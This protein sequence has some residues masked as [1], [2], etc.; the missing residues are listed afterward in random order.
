[1][2]SQVSNDP[3]LNAGEPWVATDPRRPSIVLTAWTTTTENPAS[4]TKQGYCGLARSTDGGQTWAREATQHLWGTQLGEPG[5]V[6]LAVAPDGT[7]YFECDLTASSGRI[8]I[9]KSTDGGLSWSPPVE[10]FG[11]DRWPAATLANGTPTVSWDRPV[12]VVD[13]TTG[14]VYVSASDD[15]LWGRAVAVSTDRGQTWSAPHLLDPNGQSDWGDVI[16]AA[17]GVLAAGYVVDP[18]SADYRLAASRAVDCAQPCVVF[19][20]SADHGVTWSR[21]VVPVHGAPGGNPVNLPANPRVNVAADPAH[22]GRFA[23]LLPTNS[24]ESLEIWVTEDSGDHWAR[25]RV[26]AAPTG[27][28]QAKWWVAY[29]PTGA[30]GAVWRTVHSDGSYDVSAVVSTDGGFTFGPMVPLT[31]KPSPPSGIGD[32]CACNVHLDGRTL[33]TAWGD[34]RTGHREAWFARFPYAGVPTGAH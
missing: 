29:S 18:A 19:E 15:A 13:P 17:G 24:Y 9:V 4:I 32:D 20:T 30:L 27:D 22:P 31:S 11:A 14:D 34:S 25:T 2:E 1:M 21:H 10:V 33:S 23:L 28:T 3:S 6:A 8:E 12:L 26:L 16:D 7:F 5:D